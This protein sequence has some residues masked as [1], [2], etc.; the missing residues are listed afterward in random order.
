MTKG[1]SLGLW[2]LAG[3]WWWVG[4]PER[5][6]V[7]R[8]SP[9]C[10]LVPFS[11]RAASWAPAKSEHPAHTWAAVLS[12]LLPHPSLLFLPSCLSIL[13]PAWQPQLIFSWVSWLRQ[14]VLA[15]PLPWA[16][17]RG[18]GLLE[19]KWGPSSL[20]GVE[21]QHRGSLICSIADLHPYFMVLELTL[22]EFCFSPCS[23]ITLPAPPFPQVPP[24][25][26]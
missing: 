18:P 16:G 8:R 20:Q 3:L 10:S 25:R 26:R 22:H 4:D 23:W 7:S 1:V 11:S 15:W 12:A 13:N 5:A 24:G 17:A 21:F 2:S 6:A 19:A 14:L 9:W